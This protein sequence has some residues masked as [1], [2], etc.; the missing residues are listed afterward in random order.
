VD[1]R[2]RHDGGDARAFLV[3]RDQRE[4]RLHA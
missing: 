4:D 1:P 3:T 2:T